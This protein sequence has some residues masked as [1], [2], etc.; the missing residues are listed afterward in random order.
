MKWLIIFTTILLDQLSKRFAVLY[1]KELERI[2]VIEGFFHLRYLEN[3]GAAFGL[4]QDRQLF[5]L[6]ITTVIVGWIFWFLIKNP[7]MNRL[8]VISLSLISGG[9]IGNFIDRLFFGYV[10]DFFD[11]LVWPVF[12]IADIAIVIGQVLLIYFIIK[13]KPINEGM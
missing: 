9:A 6:V 7:K 4:L 11:F 13:D 2:P 1:L 8:L 12:N 10:V 5:F 3:R